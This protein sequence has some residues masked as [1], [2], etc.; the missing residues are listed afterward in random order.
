MAVKISPEELLEFK[1]D[2]GELLEAFYNTV[3]TQDQ[4][5]CIT[6]LN[7]IYEHYISIHI[8]YQKT[9]GGTVQIETMGIIDFRYKEAL[10]DID[11]VLRRVVQETALGEST[12]LSALPCKQ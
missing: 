5:I 7:R 10:N 8:Y 4:N 12:L 1:E 9:N 3:L 2:F 11:H 6:N